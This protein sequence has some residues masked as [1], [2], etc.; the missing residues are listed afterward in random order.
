M[1]LTFEIGGS[2]I[3]AGLYDPAG[4]RVLRE[5]RAPTPSFV[6][7]PAADTGTILERLGRRLAELAV[8]LGAEAPDA[9]GIGY[10]GPVSPEGIALSSPT[11]LG[12][13]RDR[14][15]DVAAL[16]RAHLRAPDVVVVNDVTACGYRYVAEGL[17]DFCLVN[18]G[19][20]VG[21]KLFLDGRAVV[22][23][24]GRGG[25]M[26]HFA[27]DMRPD[28]PLCQCGGRGHLAGIASGRGV[29][30][31]LRRAAAAG[32]TTAEIVAAFHAGDPWTRARIAETAAPLAHAVAG[33]HAM[34]GVE[35]FILLGGF[36]LA[37][38]EP[39][40]ALLAELCARAVW[41]LGQ[42]WDAMLTLGEPGDQ[43]GLLGLGYVAGRSR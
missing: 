1:I 23:P 39:Y 33:L 16:V 7:E 37:M 25:E 3:R 4:H 31:H 2:S 20:G 24:G 28:A 43:D 27:M 29:E 34:V 19:S 14:P 13:G 5:A 12:E 11:I 6:T 10:P 35:R 8:G 30:A 17:R 40:R 15:V 18:V 22:G 9:V 38:G 21:N 36:A 42:D 26:G 41:D 32:P